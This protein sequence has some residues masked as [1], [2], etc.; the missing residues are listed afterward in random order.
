[1]KRTFEALT[2][3]V[4][5]TIDDDLPIVE[6]ARGVIDGYREVT[7]VAELAYHLR[8]GERPGLACAGRF[9]A[10]VDDVYDLVPG[11]ELDLYQQLVQRAAPGWVLHAAA[12]EHDGRAIVLAGPSGAGKTTLT[13]A[14]A[15]RGW[16]VMTEEIVLI[17]RQCAV[18]GLA[19]P[20]HA[21]RGGPQHRAIPSEWRQL[22]YPMRGPDGPIDAIIA[23]PP[24][25]GRITSALP[26]GALVRIDHAA[27]QPAGLEVMRPRAALQQLWTCTLR[28]DDEGLAA[29]LEILRVAQPFALMSRSVDD[30]VQLI[31]QLVSG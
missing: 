28:Q 17:D 1:V 15:A 7:E 11:L 5:V 8:G 26:L 20:I 30:A 6:L 24:T 27:D 19:R 12:L 31:E 16:R 14:L 22:D 9:D 25:A 29:A 4:E 3:I 13:L 2:T 18:R 10:Q 23:H 21:I